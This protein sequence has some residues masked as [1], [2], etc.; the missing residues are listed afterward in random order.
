MKAF[1]RIA[2]ALL[3]CLGTTALATAETPPGSKS[4][5]LFRNSNS[6]NDVVR[7]NSI[8]STIWSW[9]DLENFSSLAHDEAIR[10]ELPKILHEE[11]T[12]RL[13]R[14]LQEE[15][16]LLIQDEGTA[17]AFDPNDII[18]SVTFSEICK[19]FE[20]WSLH[21]CDQNTLLCFLTPTTSSCLP[22][23]CTLLV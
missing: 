2:L 6:E 18:V 7:D 21:I 19:S 10:F 17:E 14:R 5:R 13:H 9:I 12:E 15:E 4:S 1:S 23:F 22:V 3:L 16:E 8:S 20:R 11:D